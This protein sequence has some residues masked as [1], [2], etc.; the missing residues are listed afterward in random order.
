MGIPVLGYLFTALKCVAVTGVIN[1][2]Q[3]TARWEV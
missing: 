2:K 3:P 1:N